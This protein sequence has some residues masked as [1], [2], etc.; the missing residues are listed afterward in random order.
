MHIF[1]PQPVSSDPEKVGGFVLLKPG[2]THHARFMG[3][4]LYV[5]KIFILSHMFAR[6]TPRQQ[7]SI[8]R[9][10]QYI[11]TLYGRYFLSVQMSATAPMLDLDFFYDLKMYK[12]VD[13]DIADCALSSVKKHLWYLTP[14][15]VMLG[16]FNANMSIDDKQLMA[17]TLQTYEKPLVFEEGKPNF[18]T[19]IEKLGDKKPPL[20]V[21]IN[22]QS[23]VLFERAKPYLILT[24]NQTHGWSLVEAD[25]APFSWLQE[26]PAVWTDYD[27][28]LWLRKWVS[29]LEV[30]N[31]A[32]ERAVKN[33]QEV[34]C[35]AR[36]LRHREDIMIVMNKHRE[37]VNYKTKKGFC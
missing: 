22:E 11:V 20:S 29:Q 4:S 33:S 26:H 7:S 9:L 2:A 27:E 15:L 37:N 25:K 34:A 30:T 19:I 14:E 12:Q 32:A 10:T 5:L 1:S 23:W 24:E 17:A 35:A 18:E 3:K 21:F 36:D 28:F 6:L 31:D 13:K 16:L 8:D